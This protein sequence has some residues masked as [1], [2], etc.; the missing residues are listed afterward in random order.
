MPFVIF[1]EQAKREQC[2]R[3]SKFYSRAFGNLARFDQAQ[4][5]QTWD[6][7]QKVLKRARESYKASFVVN[8]SEVV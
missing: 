7:A 4:V 1:Q 6:D 2:S 3:S 5:F 8:L